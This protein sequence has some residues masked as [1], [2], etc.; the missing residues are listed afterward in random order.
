MNGQWHGNAL[1]DGKF[2]HVA[3]LALCLVDAAIGTTA[4]EAHDPIALVDSL[5]GVVSGEHGLR[6]IGGI[7]RGVGSAS[8]SFPAVH[9]GKKVC[10]DTEKKMRFR[11]DYAWCLRESGRLGVGREP[12]GALSAG[13]ASHDHQT[14]GSRRA[15]SSARRCGASG[16]GRRDSAAESDILEW[17]HRNGK[18]GPLKAATT[19]LRRAARAEADVEG[20]P[21]AD[22]GLDELC[23]IVCPRLLHGIFKCACRQMAGYIISCMVDFWSCDLSICECCCCLPAE[24]HLLS[25]G[26]ANHCI[27]A[28]HASRI[29]VPPLPEFAVLHEDAEHCNTQ[30]GSKLL[31]LRAMS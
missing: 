14:H 11:W 20:G 26:T 5:L 12:C 8:M 29:A 7:C 6:G 3:I 30:L 22:E 2:A 15:T 31:L 1:L 10:R 21:P 27:A 25:L 9:M 17:R 4:D 24:P 16:S 18:H 28:S 13:G 19:L 23:C